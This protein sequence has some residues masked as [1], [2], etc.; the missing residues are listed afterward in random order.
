MLAVIKSGFKKGLGV[1]RGLG[2]YA[3][4]VGARG[5]YL[6]PK[7]HGLFIG[8]GPMTLCLGV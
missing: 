4:L 6:D 5:F 7:N 3:Y 8:V 2:V 1:Y